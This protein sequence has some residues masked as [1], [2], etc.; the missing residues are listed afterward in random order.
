[1]T[2]KEEDEMGVVIGRMDSQVAKIFLGN[3]LTRSTQDYD[4]ILQDA[5]VPEEEKERIRAAQ[6][7]KEEDEI[8]L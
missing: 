7:K 2:E 8:I 3:N 6:K 1:M 5:S 4:R